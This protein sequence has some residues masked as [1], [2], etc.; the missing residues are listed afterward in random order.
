MRMGLDAE[1][2]VRV[3]EIIQAF[4]SNTRVLKSKGTSGLRVL[5]VEPIGEVFKERRT[6]AM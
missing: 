4:Q 6:C 1:D 5:L 3:Q 2:N